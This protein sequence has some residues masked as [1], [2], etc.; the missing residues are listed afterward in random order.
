MVSRYLKEQRSISASLESLVGR[1]HR[2]IFVAAL[3]GK[4]ERDLTDLFCS[5]IDASFSEGELDERY[6]ERFGT[7]LSMVCR[8]PGRHMSSRAA[9]LEDLSTAMDYLLKRPIPSLIPAVK[10]NIAYA[11]PGSTSLPEIASFPGRISDRSGRLMSPLPPEFG[12]SRH[13]A[14]MVLATMQ[15]E[16]R[17][18]AC[19]NL[20]YDDEVNMALSH[21]GVDPVQMNRGADGF[22][23]NT[24]GLDG[25]GF[26]YLVDPGD[27][28]IEPCLYIFGRSPLDVVHESVELQRTMDE[29]R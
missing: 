27:F 29:I 21:M 1:I 6:R 19:I 20:R 16:Q 23:F 15:M 24:S 2:E 9:V 28:G 7:E 26:L 5:I 18:R 25:T 11:L 12:V 3:A 17:A 10:V 8:G 4:E 13:L 14:G 22:A